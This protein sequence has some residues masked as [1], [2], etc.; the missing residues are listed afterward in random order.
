MWVSYFAIIKN[1]S[2][3]RRHWDSSDSSENDVDSNRSEWERV[4]GSQNDFDSFPTPQRKARRWDATPVDSRVDDLSTETPRRTRWDATP[5]NISAT[6][7]PSYKLQDTGTSYDSLSAEQKIL[8]RKDREMEERN[9][10]WTDYE[11]DCQLPTEGY[12]VL[13]APSGYVPLRTPSR[14]LTATP[15]SSTRG[16]MMGIES[17]PGLGLIQTSSLSGISQDDVISLLK[18][19]DYPFFSKIVTT[20]EVDLET[21]ED[22]SVDTIRELKLL[23]LLIR[24]KNGT[25]PMRR[26]AMRQISENA[27]DF[28]PKLLFDKL[29]PLLMSTTLEDQERHL[30]VKVVDRV[31]HQL[32]DLV[33]PFVRNILVVVEPLLIDED[34]FARQEGRDIISHL[35]K[36]AG[37]ASMVAAMRP[38]I[39]HSD[40]YVRNTTSRAFSVV[41]SA[42]GIPALLPFLK[43]VCASK[44]TWEARHTGAKIIQQIAIIMGPGV[45]PHLEQLV[46]CLLLTIQDEHPKVR[47]MSALTIA[48]LAEA[49]NPYGIEHF[50]PILKS[51]WDGLSQHRGKSLTAFLKAIGFILPLMNSEY[52]ALYAREVLVVLKREF[53]TADDELKKIV[54]LVLSQCVGTE[55]ILASEIQESIIPDFLK[56]FW[57]RRMSLDKRN[58]RQLIATTVALSKKVGIISILQHLVQDCKDES[59]AYRR[60]VIEAIDSLI[61]AHGAND[62]DQRLEEQLIDGLL[63]AFQEQSNVL[64]SGASL[65]HYQLLHDENIIL[66]GFGRIL[67]V[68]G[69]RVQPYVKQLCSIVLWRLDN[70]NARVRQQ[71]ADLLTRIAS[72]LVTCHEEDL[73][74]QLSMILYESLGEEYPD[75]LGS[76]LCALKSI[77][78]AIGA[79]KMNPPMRELLPRLT[80]ILKNRNEKVQENCINLVGCVA[81]SAPE[82]VSP[83]EW[84]RICFELLELLKAQKK[85]IRRSAIATF[86][87]IA[88]AIGPQDVLVALLNNLKVQERQLRVCTTIAIAIIAENCGSFAILPALMNE[89]RVPELN[90][91]NGVLK[92]LSFLFEYIGDTSKDYVY[93]VVRLLEDAL[94]DRDLVHRQTSCNAVKHLSLGV[95]YFGCEDAIVHLFNHVWPNILETSPHVIQAVMDAMEGFRIAL[96]PGILYRHIIQGLF[97]PARRVRSIMWNVYNTLYLNCQDSLVPH[98]AELQLDRG[99]YCRRELYLIV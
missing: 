20:N 74:R 14:K 2:D 39:D 33:R 73:L 63:F 93:S 82:D 11:L 29:L 5:V 34:Y 70:K 19:D 43:A 61:A 24:I 26:S 22:L 68:L 69:I 65:N 40:E 72:V 97:H 58:S 60:M 87:Y 71:A 32:E 80:P 62:I 81:E 6:S 30:L 67:N 28:G 96:G 56:Y 57:T 16:F 41:A 98:Y 1:M 18:P 12:A 95:A 15:T 52:S 47:T 89:Y 50:Q 25:P 42:L 51:L 37:L 13:E 86:G 55:G 53:T 79:S 99:K 85:S 92:S 27:K 91:Q 83:R 21:S 38:D 48:S 44:R 54:L 78:Q 4:S 8:L 75:V 49:C 31:L 7:T 88:K 23:K 90:V 9:R 76:L 10:P 35:S 77:L 3:K 59:E 66:N 46:S 84:M 45:L 36:A 64:G 94:I 17:T